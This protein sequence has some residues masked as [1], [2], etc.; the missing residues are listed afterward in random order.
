MP[1]VRRPII[2]MK[3][4]RPVRARQHL[5][6]RRQEVHLAERRRQRA[7]SVSRTR[8]SPDMEHQEKV[9]GSPRKSQPPN[10]P[11]ANVH[12]DK[13]P[14]HLGPRR[15]VKVALDFR[16]H[17]RKDNGR[18]RSR[19]PALTCAGPTQYRKLE[20]GMEITHR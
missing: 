2:E 3:R 19:C 12:K 13:A 17:S 9:V 6:I 14:L 7:Q 10:E 5:E 20:A 15:Q 4:R 11:Q 8:W 16:R 18:G 1:T